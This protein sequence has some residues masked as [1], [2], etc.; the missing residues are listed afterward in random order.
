MMPNPCTHHGA[1]VCGGL[2][3]ILGGENSTEMYCFNPKQNKWSTHD[4]TLRLKDCS[5][6]S[7]NEEKSCM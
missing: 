6:T 1:A 3:Y 7:F 4:I 5:V 2:L